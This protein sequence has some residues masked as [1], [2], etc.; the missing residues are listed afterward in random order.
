MPSVV[1]PIEELEK[2]A[3]E[4]H[5]LRNEHKNEAE[6]SSTRRVIASRLEALDDRFQH[7]LQHWVD[8]EPKRKAWHDFLH[9]ET[10][11]PEDDLT[12]NPPVY[13]GK[14]DSGSEVQVRP[15]G[16]HSFDVL[17]D[18]NCV[19]QLSGMLSFPMN[20]PVNLCGQKWWETSNTH[21]A[22]LTALREYC[23]QE[24]GKRSPP[25]QWARVLYGD[26]L[27]DANF[28]LTTRGRRILY[29]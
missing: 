9:H 20:A 19:E 16:G 11:C 7:L 22:A 1:H 25:W 24:K 12:A 23:A 28:S 13:I 8:N 18:G 17:I 10:A 2:I 21:G 26:G 3:S 15:T 5:H 4:F 29:R 14:S 6:H 27:I